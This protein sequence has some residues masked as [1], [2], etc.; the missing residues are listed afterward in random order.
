MPVPAS[1]AE[2]EANT[3]VV[4]GHSVS[5][6]DVLRTIAEV[7]RLGK[8]AFLALH[9]Y[10]P[11][12]RYHL[13]HNGRSYPSKAVLGV[14][15]G[16]TASQFFGGASH[17]VAS[18]GRLGFHVRNSET[19]SLVR[20]LGMN[21]LR[22]AAIEV[23]FDNP[24]P[25]WP[26]LPVTPSGYFL[27]GSNR[28]AEIR[29]L[30]TIGL[31]IGVCVECLSE[32]GIKELE[33]LAGSDVLVFADSG[34][35]SEV[36]FSPETG[37]LEVTNPIT[38]QEWSR[39]LSTMARLARSLGPQLFAVAPDLVGSQEGT[40]ERLGRYSAEVRS[41]HSAGA[42]VLVAMQKGE[43]EQS[44][45]A[46]AVDR[47]LGFDSWIPALP[48]KKAA[49]SPE[50]VA[51]FLASRNPEHVHLLGLG[52]RN[53][54]VSRYLEPFQGLNCSVSMD[55]CWIAANVGRGQKP[56]RLTLARDCAREA[57][58]LA[59]QNVDP[60]M[61]TELAL[62]LC[63][64]EPVPSAEVAEVAALR[65]RL[66]D[67]DTPQFGRLQVSASSKE[68]A[69]EVARRYRGYSDLRLVPFYRFCDRCESK[70]CCCPPREERP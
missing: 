3:V 63:L 1:R 52:I 66:Y 45:F 9:G 7:D 32:N 10:R 2:A 49:T 30:G 53:R 26:R 70:P 33:A 6:A 57:L 4:K 40:L 56:R 60:S 67:F 14:A 16:L 46:D 58:R 28:P 15:A 20:A 47:A 65:E 18:L 38:E 55:S 61:V 34:A 43:L 12:V 36:A 19:G 68:E 59:G 39:R 64:G 48:C 13:R 11:S 23:G 8:S 29:S 27:S 50:E 37:R 42:R 69:R 35:F 31:D 22:K 5:R 41:L 24:A 21:A 51:R 44:D 62:L 54:A 17:T 25:N